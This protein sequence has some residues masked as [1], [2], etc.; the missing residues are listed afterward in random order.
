M[1]HYMQAG[2][3]EGRKRETRR[4]SRTGRDSGLRE[5]EEAA[6]RVGAQAEKN[7]DEGRAE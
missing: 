1:M 5:E 4:P 7:K 6:Q 3:W 2:G